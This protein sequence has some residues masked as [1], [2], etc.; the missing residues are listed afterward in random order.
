MSKIKELS[1]QQAYRL[2][3]LKKLGFNTTD[4][5][6]PCKEFIGQE[7]PYRAIQFGLGMEHAGY[8]LY[9][10]GPTGVGKKSVIKEILTKLAK[11]RP[12]PPDWC[13]VYNMHEP[14]EPKAI[15]FPTGMG[16]VFKKDME[17]LLDLMRTEIPKA[18]EKKEFEEQKMNI[19]NEF[20]R[21]KN[22]SLRRQ[23]S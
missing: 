8:N 1:A 2:F 4:E 23:A 10:A 20:Q 5:L 18:F 12:T 3:E 22:I 13:Y 21:N 17:E 16:K 7:R 14:N 11:E 9:L 15:C 6:P 19:M